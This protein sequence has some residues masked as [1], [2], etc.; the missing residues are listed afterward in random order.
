MKGVGLGYVPFGGWLYVAGYVVDV[1]LML[2]ET[3]LLVLCNVG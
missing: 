3:N 1:C 2:N